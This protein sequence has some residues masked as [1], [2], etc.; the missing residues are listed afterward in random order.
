[1]KRRRPT[2]TIADPYTGSGGGTSATI[3]AAA[4][5]EDDADVGT[6]TG[7]CNACNRLIGV[8]R[9]IEVVRRK[10][11]RESAKES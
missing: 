6:G 3:F 4:A 1:M 8:R 10:I 7:T 9:L 5:D 11:E 2:S